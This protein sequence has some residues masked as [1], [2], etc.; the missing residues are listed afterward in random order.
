MKNMIIALTLLLAGWLI[1]VPVQAQQVEVELQVGLLVDGSAT[2]SATDF[3]IVTDA[4]ARAITEDDLIPMDGSIEVTVVQFSDQS[5][6][7]ELEPTVLTQTSASIIANS[8]RSM[9]QRGGGTPLWLGIDRITTLITGSPNFSSASR[10]VLNIATDG[11]P[12]VPVQGISDEEG[13]RLSIEAR[14]RA[15]NSGI[16]EIDAEGVGDAT[17]TQSFQDFL[18]EFVWPQPGVFF[19]QQNGTD[20]GFVSLVSNFQGFEEAIRNKIT[21][22]LTIAGI[23][24]GGNGNNND[25]GN[26]NGDGDRRPGNGVP[27][28]FDS[29]WSVIVLVV[30]MIAT[31]I[32]LRRFEPAR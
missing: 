19:N 16:D 9:N 18:L 22:I 5:A 7:V 27:I 24:V 12:K 8:I 1:A 13:A 28:P 2:I 23:P 3:D 31:L 25:D 26:N 21:R 15:V 10:Q 17:S 6:T 32:F 14:D 11:E 29:P 30:L 4:L 20:A